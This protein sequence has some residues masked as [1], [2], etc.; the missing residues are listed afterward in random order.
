MSSEPVLS[1]VPL[2]DPP[3]RTVLD[4][5]HQSAGQEPSTGSTRGEL[6]Y[7][8]C[9]ALWATRVV[10]FAGSLGPSVIYLAAAVRDNGGGVVIGTEAAPGE[11]ALASRD[12]AEAGLAEFADV[13]PGDARKTLRDVGGPIDFALIEG[14]PLSVGPS[15]ARQVIEV[16]APQM[17]ARALVL[18]DHGES[19]YLEFVRD[20]GRGF[21]S[22]SLPLTGLAELSVKVRRTG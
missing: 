17:R 3:A 8:L 18:N 7:L 9:R 20:P 6:A 1:P 2:I 22:V 10:A 15:L 11:A 19:D 12:L 21:R 4:R 14:S 5:L 13:R 16:V